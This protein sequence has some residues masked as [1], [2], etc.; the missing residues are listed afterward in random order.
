MRMS[1]SPVSLFGA[2]LQGQMTLTEWMD[3][4]VELGLDGIECGPLLIKPLGP[5]TPTEF[6]RL[7]DERGLVVSTGH[8]RQAHP[9][10]A[11][12]CVRQR[13]P[14]DR[15]ARVGAEHQLAVDDGGKNVNGRL[16]AVYP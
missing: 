13:R 15:R 2:I 4:A 5:A 8:C 11:V 12:R 10:N 16:A 1:C 9:P 7:A 6:R 14:R 3:C